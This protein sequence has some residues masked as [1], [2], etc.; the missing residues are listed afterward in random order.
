MLCFLQGFI[1]VRVT[2]FTTHGRRIHIPRRQ[3][4]WNI[5]SYNFIAHV[6]YC[7]SVHLEALLGGLALFISTAVLVDGRLGRALVFGEV[8]HL[9]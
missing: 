7:A 8:F 5:E 9:R 6:C 2:D 4:S 1:V 3:C